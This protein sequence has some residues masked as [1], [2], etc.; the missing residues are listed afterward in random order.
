MFWKWRKKMQTPSRK[1]STVLLDF[2]FGEP[3]PVPEVIEDDTAS[4]WQNWLDA[5]ARQETSLDFEPT[6]PMV[7]H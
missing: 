7:L 2:V 3:L 4:A 1:V 5:V 6:M